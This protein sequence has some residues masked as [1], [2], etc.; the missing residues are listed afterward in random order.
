M[1]IDFIKDAVGTV[2]DV[3]SGGKGGRSAFSQQDVEG[4]RE[5]VDPGAFQIGGGDAFRQRQRQAF[6]RAGTTFEDPYSRDTNEFVRALQAQ[7]RGEGPSLAQNQF[8]QALDQGIATQRAQAAT[9]GFDPMARRLAAQN[10]GDLTQRGARDSA[11][12]RA[13]EQLSAQ[14]QLAQALQARQSDQ[15]QRAQMAENLRLQYEQLGFSREQAEQQALQ[16]MESQIFQ[17]LGVQGELRESAAGRAQKTIGG[18]LGGGAEAG[19]ALI[20][21]S[22]QNSKE[23]IGD[24]NPVINDFLDAI[25][26][27]QYD[28]KDGSGD[29]LVGVMAQDLE[30]SPVTE[31]MVMDSPDGKMVDYGQ[32]FAAMMAALANLN[33]RLN[34]MEGQ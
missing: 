9:G 10:I 28:Y 4:M 14:Q 31:Q 15:L 19:A 22:D 25:S 27:K 26:A 16:D 33:Q 5:L 6:G 12:L 18:I 20:K 2:G 34:K 13:Q 11:M 21:K 24:G 3:L 23:N 1:P 29:N 8:N 17:N 30:K 7:M 32:G